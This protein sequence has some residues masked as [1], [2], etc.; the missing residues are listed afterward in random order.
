MIYATVGTGFKAG[1]FFPAIVTSTTTNSYKPETITSWTLG[2]KNRFLDN[3]LQLNAEAFYWNYK[4]KQV[5]HLA[6]IFNPT[7]SPTFLSP[8][9]VTENAGNAKFYGL[10]LDLRFRATSYD[11]IA[12][13]IQYEHSQYDSYVYKQPGTAVP[14]T[15]CNGTVLAGVVTIDCSGKTV[16]FTPSL[17][18]NLNYSH[19][20]PFASGADLA[21][22][23][24]ARYKSGNWISDAYA[25]GNYQD[26]ATK[27][28]LSA[29]YH[30]PGGKWSA[31]AYVD[32]VTNKATLTLGSLNTFNASAL[33]GIEAPRTFGVRAG[34]KW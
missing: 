2:S 27:A 18:L 33:A 12:G 13:T 9:L 25:L 31:M 4:D 16:P 7:N 26:A 24:A 22:S 1:G 32:N 19:V 11:V 6:N 20:T 15:G 3:S 30:A 28:D 34:F 8:G 14:I 17:T 23:I 29:T 5:S 21:F 10:E